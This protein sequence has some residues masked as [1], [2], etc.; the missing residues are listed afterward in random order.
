MQV[1][2]TSV[3]L[4]DTAKLIRRDLRAEFPGTKFSVRG[5]SFSMGTAIDIGWTDGPLT[6]TVDA[7][8]RVYQAG[9]FNGMDD[10][11]EYEST[12][13]A[14][15]D[16]SLVDVSYGAK[17]VQTQRDVSEQRERIYWRELERF[18]GHKLG[19]PSTRYGEGPTVDVSVIQ[20]DY[21]DMQGQLCQ[22]SRHG[23]PESARA[24]VRQMGYARPWHGKPCPGGEGTYCPGC[25]RYQADHRGPHLH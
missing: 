14:N 6:K 15:E 7:V 23:F 9:H 24:I 1:T 8:V 18:V 11:Y 21:Q 13:V 5:R 16:G 22:G 3:S 19:K 20:H 25:G 17:Y 10:L 4:K 2:R 12:L